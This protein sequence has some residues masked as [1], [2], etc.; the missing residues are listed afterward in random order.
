M[1]ADGGYIVALPSIQPKGRACIW[2]V[3]GSP[4]DLV[5]RFI[6]RDFDLDNMQPSSERTDR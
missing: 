1:R 6:G 2:E 4:D 3:L 5:Y